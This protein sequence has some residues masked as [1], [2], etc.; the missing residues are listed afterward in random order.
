MMLRLSAL[1]LLASSALGYDSF[2]VQSKAGQKLLSK[3]TV[4]EPARNLAD[5]NYG[6]L[7][8]YSIKYTGCTDI[9][10]INREGGGNNNNNN[11]E[12][13]LLYTQHLVK[14][15]LCPSAE[16]CSTC[17]GGGQYV[18]AMEDFVDAYTEAKLTEQEYA[19][20]MIREN[21][22]CN[23]YN[24]DEACANSCYMQA[25]MDVCIEYEGQ[26]EFEIQRYLECAGTCCYW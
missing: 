8:K 9:V 19:C 6:Y 11:G 18:V 26:E 1:A 4:I 12:G 5:N 25:G 17:S 21:C 10:Q 13:G 22:Y 14:F 23:G 24:D 3:A 7:Y 15:S 20:E 16:G 2:D